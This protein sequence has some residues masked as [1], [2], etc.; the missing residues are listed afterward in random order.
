MLK[1]FDKILVGLL[2]E[3]ETALLA[4]SGGRDSMC[5]A[6]LFMESGRDFAIV[7]FICAGKRV[8]PMRILSGNGLSKTT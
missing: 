3:K 1:K 4:V 2:P 5:M 6:Q 8:I 7:T